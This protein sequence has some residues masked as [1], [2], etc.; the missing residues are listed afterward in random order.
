MSRRPRSTRGAS[1]PAETPGYDVTF[2]DTT[3]RNLKLTRH[4]TIFDVDPNNG[5]HYREGRVSRI[6]WE[7]NGDTASD[8]LGK[9]LSYSLDV[10]RVSFDGK[11]SVF[12]L[13]KK[14]DDL[15]DLLYEAIHDI[16]FFAA[17]TTTTSP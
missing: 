8:L 1:F 6:C 10:D 16:D 9:F 11:S 3:G 13:F 14:C 15:P 7:R 2:V 12:I 5:N 17:R 4:E